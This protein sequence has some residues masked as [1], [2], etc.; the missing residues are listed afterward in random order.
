MIPTI[1]Q[2]WRVTNVGYTRRPNEKKYM[3]L[4]IGQRWHY[5]GNNKTQY[6]VEIIYINKL[7]DYVRVKVVQIFDNCVFGVGDEYCSDGLHRILVGKP[8]TLGTWEYLEGQD[9]I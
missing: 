8:I 1:G 2:R 7:H 9:V 4:A 3:I 6:I 5:V